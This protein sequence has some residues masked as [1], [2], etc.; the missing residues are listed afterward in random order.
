[1]NLPKET[2]SVHTG[3]EIEKT[4]WTKGVMSDFFHMYQPKTISGK[5]MQSDGAYVVY[6]A[7][8]PIGRYSSYNHEESEVT[9]T[10]RGAT[11]GTVNVTP[12][13]VWITGNAMIVR[14]KI[15]GLSKEFTAVALRHMGFEKAITGAAQ[16]QITRT[17]LDSIPF[18]FPDVDEQKRIVAKLDEV[19]S[20]CRTLA[21][22]QSTQILQLENYY[23]SAV[24]A[25][26]RHDGDKW[27]L[28]QLSDVTNKIGSGATPKGGESSYVASG[29][30]LIRSLNVHD[31]EFRL[32]NLAHITEEQAQKLNNVVVQKDDILLNIT[33]ASIARTCQVDESILPA[34]VNQHVSI[35]RPDTDKVVPKYLSILLMSRDTKVRLLNTGASGGT[36]RQAL[37]KADLEGF[38]IHIPK[39]IVEQERRGQQCTDIDNLIV[40]LRNNL[41]NRQDLVNDLNSSILAV[42]MSGD[43]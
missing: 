11:C 40:Q 43:L 17:S 26:M 10:C 9:V 34:R 33:G 12:P 35:I 18:Q 37:T 1:M 19:L 20:V 2:P 25:L 39:E 29:I 7:N 27:T 38:E 28:V 22:T 3:P 30:S 6:G 24:Q 16:P 13:K 42:A 41:D 5:D 8:G 32:K 31:S 36:T 14:P 21:K 23:L 4:E 15:N